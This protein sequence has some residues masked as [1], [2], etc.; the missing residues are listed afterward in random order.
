MPRVVRFH[1]TGGP[2]VLQ[3]ET[4]DVPPPGAGEVR[5]AVKAL[6]LTAPSRCSD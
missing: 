2:E 5:M 6:G 3:I 4:I 1:Q